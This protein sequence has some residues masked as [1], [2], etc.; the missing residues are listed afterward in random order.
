MI[1]SQNIIIIII[2]IIIITI[3]FSACQHEACRLRN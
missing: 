1:D 2:I 3:F